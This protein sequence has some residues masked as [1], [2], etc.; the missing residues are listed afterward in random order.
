MPPSDPESS[1]WFAEEVLPHEPKLR[2]WLRGRFPG[3][4]DTDDLVQEAV[5][6]VL[7][8]HATTAV[9]S[10]KAFLYVVARNLA[11]MRARSRHVRNTGS[12]EEIDAGAILDEARE[13]QS[14]LGDQDKALSH[15]I[16]RME[17]LEKI[18]AKQAGKN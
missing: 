11:L 18:I 3:V 6:R 9:R 16:D 12:L 8:A 1:R 5:L 7:D 4:T 13:I 14:H 17:T 10:P 2:A 15:L